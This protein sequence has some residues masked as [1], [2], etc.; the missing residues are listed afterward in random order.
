MN[1]NEFS[2]A[3]SQ[4]ITFTV[5]SIGQYLLNIYYND[6]IVGNI[7]LHTENEN[8]IS[9][10]LSTNSQYFTYHIDDPEALSTESLNDFVIKFNQLVDTGV[11]DDLVT[12]TLELDNETLSLVSKAATIENITVEEFILK[13]LTDIAHG[14]KVWY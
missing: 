4:S 6:Y 7:I 5:D 12:I 2:A 14:K 13:T 8:I 9:G 3:L 11:C 10:S 1:I